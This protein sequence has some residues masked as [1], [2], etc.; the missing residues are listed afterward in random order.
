MSECCFDQL[1]IVFDFPDSIIFFLMVIFAGLNISY[2]FTMMY[3]FIGAY[4][5]NFGRKFSQ[6]SWSLSVL[7]PIILLCFSEF[8]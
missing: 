8:S 4:F 1:I 5:V 7:I 2:L 6:V 3:N